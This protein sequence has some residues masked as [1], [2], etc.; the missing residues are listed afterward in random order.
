M[1]KG[2]HGG[3]H[4]VTLAEYGDCRVTL[5]R[6]HY[7]YR[8]WWREAGE[9]KCTYRSIPTKGLLSVELFVEGQLVLSGCVRTLPETP[10]ECGAAIKA[11]KLALPLAITDEHRAQ[12]DE[13]QRRG[14]FRADHVCV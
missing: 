7:A 5:S 10:G 3:A 6:N 14:A 1:S 9:W 2:K 11:G 4:D 13:G 8:I 12:A